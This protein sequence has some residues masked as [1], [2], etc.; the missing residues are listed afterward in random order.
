M[1]T[2]HST[3]RTCLALMIG[4]LLLAFAACKKSP[5]TIGNDL[6]SDSEY[7]DVYYTDTVEIMCHSYFDSVSTKNVSYAL[8]GSMKDHVFGNS[9]AGFY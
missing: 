5:E 9:E 4:T 7:I 6:V 1:K 2:Y 8:L 3:A